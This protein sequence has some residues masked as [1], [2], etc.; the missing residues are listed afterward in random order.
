MLPLYAINLRKR[1]DRKESITRQFVDKPEFLLT[2]EYAVEHPIGAYSLWLTW[3]KIV[4]REIEAD[5]EFFI[6]CEDDH[7][8]TEHYSFSYLMKSIDD[9]RKIQADVLSGGVSWLSMPVQVKKHLFWLKGF[10]GLQFTI[11]FNQFYRT[12]LDAPFSEKV[13]ADNFIASITDNLFVMY[14]FISV[15]REFGYSDVTVTNNR[16]GQVERLFKETTE[17]LRILDKAACHYNSY[18]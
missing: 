11:V 16:E 4:Q 6:I 14:P 17:H 13:V 1:T 10:N 18:E 12:L 15:Q 7:V 9:A 2:I 5:S 3:R 8:F